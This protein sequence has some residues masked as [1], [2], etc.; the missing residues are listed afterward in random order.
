LIH[1]QTSCREADTVVTIVTET[2]EC[3]KYNFLILVSSFVDGWVKRRSAEDVIGGTG[4][5]ARE[6]RNSLL[7][8]LMHAAEYVGIENDH[9]RFILEP[10]ALTEDATGYPKLHE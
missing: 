5:I 9:A 1:S 3:E 10:F 8:R 7:N 2:R 4:S 6:K